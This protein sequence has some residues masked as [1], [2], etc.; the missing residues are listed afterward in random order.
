MPGVVG[1]TANGA[2]GEVGEA[3][4]IP[5]SSAGGG[6]A[7]PIVS[8]GHREEVCVAARTSGVV[9]SGR[10]NNFRGALASSLLCVPITSTIAVAIVADCPMT[11]L[12]GIWPTPVTLLC[13]SAAST[14][15]E[16]RRRSREVAGAGV[17]ATSTANSETACGG[18][19]EGELVRESCS[20]G[21]T[22]RPSHRATESDECCGAVVAAVIV[23]V[24]F[25]ARTLVPDDVVEVA[26]MGVVSVSLAAAVEVVVVATKVDAQARALASSESAAVSSLG[27]VMGAP[28]PTG[29]ATGAVSEKGKEVIAAPVAAEETAGRLDALS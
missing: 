23:L 29:T 26:G 18:V 20:G 24:A 13:T 1:V 16:A 19:E 11:A 14:G 10:G 3:V 12:G 5:A 21:A 2:V 28:G 17:A 8:G 25:G 27:N 9:V 7:E 4:S 15:G 6:R 22:V